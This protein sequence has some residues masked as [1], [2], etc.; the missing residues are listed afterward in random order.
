MR[1][2]FALGDVGDA[3]RQDSVTMEGVTI[4]G[5]ETYKSLDL[6]LSAWRISLLKPRRKKSRHDHHRPMGN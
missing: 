2:V 4:A 3:F 1:A 5:N 6:P